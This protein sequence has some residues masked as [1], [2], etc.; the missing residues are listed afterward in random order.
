MEVNKSHRK[1]L[2]KLETMME[3]EIEEEETSEQNKMSLELKEKHKELMRCRTFRQED[4]KI[5][6]S[7]VPPLYKNVNETIYGP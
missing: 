5:I 4:E 1:S 3:C 2:R 7:K 6:C